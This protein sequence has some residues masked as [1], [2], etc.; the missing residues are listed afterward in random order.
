MANSNQIS[1]EFP[2]LKT[3]PA[4]RN[5]E[6][7]FSG[8]EATSDAR[9]LLLREVDLKLGLTREFSKFIADPQTRI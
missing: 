1:F 5:I 7:Q 8:G 4:L 3:S 9:V 6:V 2:A